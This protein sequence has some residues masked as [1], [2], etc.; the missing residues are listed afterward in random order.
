MYSHISVPVRGGS[1]GIGMME[2]VQYIEVNQLLSGDE[3]MGQ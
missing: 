2:G 3:T 1:M